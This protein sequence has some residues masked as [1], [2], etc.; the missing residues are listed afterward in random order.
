M[1]VTEIAEFTLISAAEG[2]RGIAS[3]DGSSEGNMRHNIEWI[4]DPWAIAMQ[5]GAIKNQKSS[6]SALDLERIG[7]TEQLDKKS[8]PG[9]SIP[10]SKAF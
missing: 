10:T 1:A 8:Y 5:D 6:R 2:R 3:P 9:L 4:L 7:K